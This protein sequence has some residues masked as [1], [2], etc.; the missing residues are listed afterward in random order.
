M[1]KGHS[2][3]WKSGQCKV[4]PLRGPISIADYYSLEQNTGQIAVNLPVLLSLY[5]ALQ[6]TLPSLATKLR[7]Y[8]T[9]TR[10]D[11]SYNKSS[12]KH[13]GFSQFSDTFDLPMWTFPTGKTSDGGDDLEPGGDKDLSPLPA[14]WEAEHAGDTGNPM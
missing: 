3:A 12:K 13:F 7:S 1:G 4:Q 14:N 6:D 2:S 8:V 11:R 9:S 10:L 5:R